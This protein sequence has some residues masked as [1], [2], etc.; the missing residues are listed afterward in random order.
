M[1]IG[2]IFNIQKY[3]I[4]DGPGI[5]TTIFFKG[6]PLNCLWCH[7]PESQ[8]INKQ[9]IFSPQKC[10]ACGECYEGCTNKALIPQNSKII[11]NKEK[12]NL[13]GSCTEN[14]VTEAMEMIGEEITLK[15]LMKEIKKDMVFYEESGGGA[16]FSGGEPLIQSR[17][18]RSILKECKKLGIHTTLDTSGYG[19]WEVLKELC[20]DVDLFLYDIK[21]INDSR[22]IELTGLSNKC[23]IENLKKLVAY[24]KNIW[25]RAPIIPSIN[26]DKENIKGIGELMNS[27]SL[28]E[29]FILPYHNIGTDKYQ[30]L[31]RNY[32]LSDIN[33]PTDKHVEYIAA[34]LK[35]YGLIVKIGG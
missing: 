30:S 10:I 16:T 18:L 26:D 34:K 11:R 31:G 17:F 35:A 7:N 4:H 27:L 5:R 9:I 29:I 33:V 2:T 24:G 23:I 6:C 28:E 15:K 22:H 12:C 20:D 13:C 19:P 21:H 1:K 14:C 32:N 8:D 25:I 3:S